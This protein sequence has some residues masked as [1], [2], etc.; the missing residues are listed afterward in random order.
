MNIPSNLKKLSA[1][2]LLLAGA[3]GAQ[4]LPPEAP[5]NTTIFIAGGAANDPAFDKFIEGL[6][7]DGTFDVYYDNSNA[8]NPGSRYRAYFFTTNNSKIPGLSTG[9]TN[10]NVLIYKRSYGGAGYGV[11]PLLDP[12][13]QVKQLDI[14]K[15]NAVLPKTDAFY[16]VDPTALQNTTSDAGITGVNPELFTGINTPTPASGDPAFP[17]VDVSKASGTLTIAPAGGLAYGLTVTLDLYK[18]L[19]AAQIATGTLP[20]GTVIGDYAHEASIPTL[21]RAFVASLISGKIKTWDDVHVIDNRPIEGG[22]THGTDLGTLTSFANQAGVEP[23]TLTGGKNLVAVGNRN[24]GAAV[25]AAFSAV[26]LNSPG[27]AN[28][29][30]PAAAP[31]NPTNGP[32]VAQAP[33][34]SQQ[35]ALLNDWQVG[36]NASTFNADS[37]RRWGIAQQSTDFGASGAIGVNPSK[38]YRYVRIDGYAPTLQNVAS[39][40]YPLWSEQ[41]IQWRRPD[42]NPPGPD[43]DKLAILQKIVDDIGNPAK[44]AQVSTSLITTFGPSGVFAV[45]TNSAV[46]GITAQF[47]TTKPIVPYTHVNGGTL[48][49]SIVPVVN[50]AKPGTVAF[51]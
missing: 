8:A 24:K 37:A 39:G 10:V 1:A 28:A 12:S 11:V 15:P 2:V 47:E 51:R 27:T 31:G 23:P 34:A 44:V 42:A 19:Q 17:A 22:A 29:F 43:G 18:V 13:Y 6:A 36:A 32:I 14:K 5:V 9:A 3:Q 35:D 20:A 38:P 16:R 46:T 49:A 48:N 40:N 7:L 45:S 26:F 50:S 41:T 25:G 30:A 21:S 4:A 33:G